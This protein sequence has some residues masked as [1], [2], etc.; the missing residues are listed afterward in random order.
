MKKLIIFGNSDF[1]KLLKWYIDY[2]D[3]RKVVA[4][5]ADKEFIKEN[6][7]ESLPLIAFEE[8][9]NIYPPEEYDILLGIG[10]SKMNEIR[11]QIYYKCKQKGYKI[12][13]YIHSSVLIET[14]H[15][16]EGNII[17]EQ[18]LIEP[19]VRIGDC[20]LIWYK[21]SIAHNDVIGNFNTIAGMASLCG[22]VTIKNNCF[23][24]NS[25]VIR[26]H[27]TIDDYSLIGASAYVSKDA[28]SYSVVVAPKGI[29][30]DGK[31]STDF[32]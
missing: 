25:S 3:Q 6:T 28:D 9:E 1:S 23:I 14:D 22:Y 10:Y 4:F 2:D 15:I 30:L 16:G 11:K 20:N 31:K 8:I 21:I 13:S 29:I 17:L 12:A 27:T 18:T 5:C 24:G 7:F 26:E 19:F 32:I